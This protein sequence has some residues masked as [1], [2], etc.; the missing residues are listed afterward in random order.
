MKVIK[1]NV[2]S[3]NDHIWA[4]DRDPNKPKTQNIGHLAQISSNFYNI[5][6]IRDRDCNYFW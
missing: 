1:K 5:F 3:F 6:C 4:G 2:F